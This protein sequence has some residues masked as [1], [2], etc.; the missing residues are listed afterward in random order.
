[1]ETLQPDGIMFLGTM[2]PDPIELLCSLRSRCGH[3]TPKAAVIRSEDEIFSSRQPAYRAWRF[4][5]L[6][7]NDECRNKQTARKFFVDA[8]ARELLVSGKSVFFSPM[9][10]RLLMLLL[11]Y[12]GVVFSRK[13]LLQRA[14]S[15]ESGGDPQIIDV[16]VRRIRMK[17]EVDSAA[18]DLLRTA[19]GLGYKFTGN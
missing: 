7:Q 11:R 2:T 14:A 5:N 9:E 3:G 4:Q 10:F 8:R 18:P 1:V 16:I 12:P 17:I 13:E 15:Y 19:R 6:L